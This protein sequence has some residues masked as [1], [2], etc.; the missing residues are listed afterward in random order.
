MVAE[1]LMGEILFYH[2]SEHRLERALPVLVERSLARGWRVV[3]QA[4]EGTDLAVLSRA[5]WTFRP[6][7][8]VA[9]GWGEEWRE[10]AAEQ[11]VWLTD[12]D[13]TPNGA[14]V[15]FFVE[16]A[17]PG[18]LSALKRAVFMFD[19]HDE[20]ALARARRQWA[21]LRGEGG[22]LAYWKQNDA[23]GWERGV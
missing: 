1:G 18:D 23:G 9:H 21:A 17:E 14:T 19:G 11:P 4:G 8:F 16:G 6:D 3:V 10:R 20:A 15:R 13:D 2:L 12:G 5:L 22:K 7:S